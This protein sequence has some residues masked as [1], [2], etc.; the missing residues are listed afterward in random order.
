MTIMTT[1]FLWMLSVGT[2]LSASTT[3]AVF[4]NRPPALVWVGI[5]QIIA[6]VSLAHYSEK[7][8][9]YRRQESKWVL[10][11]MQISSA[12]LKKS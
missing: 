4:L 5:S 6:F 10:E 12:H 8:L 11:I 3:Y 2:S 7:A 1:K 9:L